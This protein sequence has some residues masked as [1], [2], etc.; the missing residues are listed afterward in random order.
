MEMDVK[1]QNSLEAGQKLINL[2][3]FTPSIHCMYYAVLQMMKYCLAHLKVNPVDYD[4]QDFLQER[5]N[6]ASHRWLFD[7]ICPKLNGRDKNIFSDDFVFLKKCR[8]H[9]DYR[10]KSFNAEES[11]GCRDIAVRLISKLKKLA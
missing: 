10:L 9:A 5:N 4:R 6:K 1:S 3:L 2:K 7:E 11:A 8:V